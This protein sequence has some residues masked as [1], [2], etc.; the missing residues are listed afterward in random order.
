MSAVGDSERRAPRQVR[1][2]HSRDS[3]PPL[4]CHSMETCDHEPLQHPFQSADLPLPR[5]PRHRLCNS[6]LFSSIR[7][8]T[9]RSSHCLRQIGEETRRGTTRISEAMNRNGAAP[10]LNMNIRRSLPAELR[11]RGLP[12]D[13]Q[14]MRYALLRVGK[15]GR[16]GLVRLPEEVAGD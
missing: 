2:N 3:D 10:D 1:R 6:V 9:R 14:R 16:R 13:L 15:R 12:V 11:I 8:G 5:Q 7:H 4:P